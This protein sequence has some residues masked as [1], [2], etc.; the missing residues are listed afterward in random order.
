MPA[1]MTK[2]LTEDAIDGEKLSSALASFE[3]FLATTKLSISSRLQYA[4]FVKQLV[5]A[6]LHE[7]T[8]EAVAHRLGQY[9][10]RS[11]QRLKSGWS[12]FQ[13][14]VRKLHGISQQPVRL[15]MGGSVIRVRHP[16]AR[17][18]ALVASCLQMETIKRARYDG[19]LGRKDANAVFSP[20]QWD[21]RVFQELSE[22]VP[23][24]KYVQLEVGLLHRTAAGELELCDAP[25]LEWIEAADAPVL[26][27]FLVALQR[28]QLAAWEN[29]VSPPDTAPVFVHDR[30][31]RM[32]GLS[33]A[34]LRAIWMAEG[35]APADI[36]T[37]ED[38]F[39]IG[40]R[41]AVH[42]ARLLAAVQK[43]GRPAREAA[44]RREAAEE[45]RKLLAAQLAEWKRMLSMTENLKPEPPDKA[46]V[47]KDVR[48]RMA[49]LQAEMDKLSSAE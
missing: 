44:E 21:N 4:S 20:L 38:Y 2:A 18:W 3:V 32:E 1:P 42:P 7:G 11:R 23:L 12:Y 28:I 36:V 17:D 16:L 30:A 26:L 29:G 15:P 31:T 6:V 9:N 39:N 27:P 25:V 24:R 35:F 8:Y 43:K 34:E 22:G 19:V 37:K 13:V 46:D 33:S 10:E 45:K 47:L 48:A 5:K 40:W 14:H 41:R 49:K